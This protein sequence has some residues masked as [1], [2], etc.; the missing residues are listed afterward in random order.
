MRTPKLQEVGFHETLFLISAYRFFSL[1]R[2]LDQRAWHFSSHIPSPW[3]LSCLT[4]K[5]ARQLETRQLVLLTCRWHVSNLWNI[6]ITEVYSVCQDPTKKPFTLYFL[7]YCKTPFQGPPSL[8]SG[9]WE[10]PK[11]HKD[12]LAVITWGRLITEL[13]TNMHPTQE[14]M[15]VGHEARKLGVFMG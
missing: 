10:H 7:I 11:K 12:P 1:S 5:S 9:V 13:R 15:D 2:W 6:V 14:I 3:H 4:P 8:V